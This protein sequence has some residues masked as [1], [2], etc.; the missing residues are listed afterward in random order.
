MNVLVCLLMQIISNNFSLLLLS[1]RKNF[2]LRKPAGVIITI[3][4]FLKLLNYTYIN[5]RYS[6][7]VILFKSLF[8]IFGC[9]RYYPTFQYINRFYSRLAIASLL[10]GIYH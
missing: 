6:I 4:Q 2:L 5:N 10:D 3:L 8:I 1:P 9:F 7:I